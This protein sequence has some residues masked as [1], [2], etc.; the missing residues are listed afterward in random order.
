MPNQNTMQ[1]IEAPTLTLLPTPKPLDVA[2]AA[3]LRRLEADG[4]SPRTLSAYARDLRAVSS[5]LTRRFPGIALAAVTPAMLDDALSDPAITGTAAGMPRSAATLHRLKAAVRSFFAWTDEMG[6]IPSNPARFVRL[7][8]LT[9]V[10]PEFLTEPEKRRLL[11]T[12]RQSN[13]PEAKRDRVIFELF[14]GT[15]IRLQ[16]LV[17]LGLDDVDLDA[18]HIRIVG[19]GNRPAIKFLKTD[20]RVLLRGYLAERRRKGSGETTA[21]FLSNRDTRLCARQVARRL[22]FWLAQASIPK[23]LGPHALRHTFATHLYARTGNILVVQRALGHANL[24]TTQVYTHLC[25][26]QLEDAIERL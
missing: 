12:L 20:L 24:S 4:A 1:P 2:I 19:K 5:V 23:R 18:K 11:K 8:R 16:E 22:D 14:L 17:N 3:Y 10:P 15:G 26:G 9:P 7:H 21:L 6:M 25:D 13:M